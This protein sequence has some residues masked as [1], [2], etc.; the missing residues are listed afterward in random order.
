MDINEFFSHFKAILLR[1]GENPSQVPAEFIPTEDV[2][3]AIQKFENLEG[4]PGYVNLTDFSRGLQTLKQIAIFF[5]VETD[6]PRFIAL[7]LKHG[8]CCGAAIADTEE[9]AIVHMIMGQPADLF[10]GVVITN[11]A[12]DEELAVLLRTH[13]AP[14]GKRTLDV[15]AVPEISV[16]ARSVLH[17]KDEKCKILVNP[18]LAEVSFQTAKPANIVRQVE[19]GFLRQPSNTFVLNLGDE[20]MERIGPL[21][22]YQWGALLFASAIGSTSDS[23]TIALARG[24]YENCY[25]IGLGV[26]QTSRV[27]AAKVAIANARAAGHDTAGSVAYSDSFFPFKDGPEVLAQAGVAAIFATSGSIHD[28][29]VAEYCRQ[30]GVTLWRLPDTVARGFFNH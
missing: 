24:S 27:G 5:H 23:N 14:G 8:N 19:G 12:I 7:G 1:Y 25:L 28:A 20:R 11:F 22:D 15:V 10:G 21:P 29:E 26:R 16:E 6:H 13:L 9:D 3:L 18:N 2:L 30:S 4:E 17:R